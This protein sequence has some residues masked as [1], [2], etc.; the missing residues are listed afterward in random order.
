M[1]SFF[2]WMFEKGLTIR[3]R[4]LATA[5]PVP[6]GKNQPR[7]AGGGHREGDTKP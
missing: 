4:R 7:P 3:R 1:F 2:K 6:A 5:D